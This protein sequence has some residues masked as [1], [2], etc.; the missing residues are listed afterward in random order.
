MR[1][2]DDDSEPVELPA[3]RGRAQSA[4][5]LLD[6]AIDE[7]DSLE[8]NEEV[9]LEQQPGDQIGRYLLIKQLGQG[10]F[11]IVWH[12]EQKEPIKREV[13]LKIIRPGMDSRGVVSRFRAE[14]KA[15]ERME[16]PHIASVLDAGA[17]EQGR[18]YFV[19]E[20]VRGR[21]I[22]HYAEEQHLSLRA[23]L[24]LFID[25]CLAVQHAHQKGIMHRDL[26][27]SNILVITQD[28]KAVPKVIDFGIA[29]ALTDEQDNLYSM[30]Y[31]AHGMVMGTPQ[32]MAPE[33]AMLGGGDMDIRV[34]VYSLGAILYELL[35]CSTPMILDRGSRTSV[36][37]LLRRIHDEEAQPPSER[38]R[39][40]K[41]QNKGAPFSARQLKGDLDWITLRALEKDPE[42]RY[43]TASIL[44]D[45]LQRYLN[46]EPVH[47]GP[48]DT[49]YRLRKLIRRHRTAFISICLVTTSL[50]TATVLSV[51]AFLQESKARLQAERLRVQAE[52]S[53]KFAVSESEKA[54]GVA[55]FLSGLLDQAGKLIDQGK[56][57]EALRLALDQSAQKLEALQGQPE[58][59]AR[60]YKHLADVYVAMGDHRRALSLRYRELGCLQNLYGSADPRTLALKLSIAEGE[61]GQGEKPKAVAMCEEIVQQW[62]AIGKR[63]S[64]GWVN[65]MSQYA[66]LLSRS[67]R[68]EEALQKML[69]LKGHQNGR[70]T[71]IE[72]DTAYLRRLAE[73]QTSIGA[74]DEATTTLK[75][76]LE[77]LPKPMQKR[78]AVQQATLTSLARLEARQNKHAEAARYFEESIALIVQLSGAE[79]HPLIEMRIE[80]A[81]QYVADGRFDEAIRST[82]AALVIAR[83]NGTDEKLPHALRASAEVREK[84]GK[85]L[86]SL[87]FREECTDAQRRLKP[88]SNL[89][90]DDHM[91]HAKLLSA[92]K[93]HDEAEQLVSVLWKETQDH[94]AAWSDDDFVRMMCDTLSDICR[95]WQAATGRN[96]HDQDIAMWEAK[97]RELRAR[98]KKSRDL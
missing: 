75:H 13:A 21:A 78:L 1:E 66:I 69:S 71:M 2:Q 27:P 83:V 95:K 8:E 53:Q 17:T 79:Y 97:A 7:G 94:P 26:K 46:D 65:A 84:G 35:T 39:Q 93:R 49:M 60:L 41:A 63:G 45:E 58:M 91:E 87:P 23:R 32:Y 55:G 15:L 85:L 70:G 11:G 34:D 74:F 50:I 67:G 57:P 96:I 10:G 56:N 33:Q 51:Y 43:S 68:G 36:D 29:K 54:I 18:P 4:L 98:K 76:S 59:Q 92:L 16:H 3:V 31:T 28:G 5:G 14:Q 44:A 61:A 12:A 52:A 86:E 6:L 47:T 62:E 20:L 25:V 89:W 77:F 19:M 64:G 22:T 90:V 30:A 81:R 82:D 72:D 9:A 37:K 42:R 40:R 80:L 24:E 88:E 38:V 48:P 73:I